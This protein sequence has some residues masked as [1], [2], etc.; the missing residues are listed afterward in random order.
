MNKLKGY[1]AFVLDCLVS[2]AVLSVM[3][4]STA[5]VV[6]SVVNYSVFYVAG[7]VLYSKLAITQGDLIRDVVVLST[8]IMISHFVNVAL[9]DR[10]Q[11]D[12]AKKAMQK[13]D[14]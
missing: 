7:S 14:E 9:L 10:R 8:V 4:F 13:C 5:L 11:S 6:L 3:F 12:A 1:F 2:F